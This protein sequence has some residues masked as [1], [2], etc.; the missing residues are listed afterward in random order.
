[1]LGNFCGVLG[2]CLI[3]GIYKLHKY[4]SNRKSKAKEDTFDIKLHAVPSSVPEALVY[5]YIDDIEK[6]VAP[7]NVQLQQNTAYGQLR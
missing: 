6:A 3:L 2:I 1:M 4:R 7:G 5:E